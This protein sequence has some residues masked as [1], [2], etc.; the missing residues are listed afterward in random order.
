MVLGGKSWCLGWFLDGFLGG[1]AEAAAVREGTRATSP[2]KR[3]GSWPR[4]FGVA[5]APMTWRPCC[6]WGEAGGGGDGPNRLDNRRF[7]EKNEIDGWSKGFILLIFLGDF[8]EILGYVGSLLK[9][10]RGA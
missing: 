3:S 9:G 6:G 5:N 4:G 1:L 7:L 8:L 2:W 10:I